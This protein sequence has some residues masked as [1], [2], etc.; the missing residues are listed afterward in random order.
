MKKNSKGFVLF[1]TLVVATFVL[2]ALIFLFVQFSN[3]KKNYEIT[4][5]YNTVPGVYNLKVLGDYI[6]SSA[7]YTTLSNNAKSS[8]DGSKLK[9][10]I[11][12]KS[13]TQAC[14]TTGLN[15]FCNEIIEKINANRVILISGA[16]TTV[17][18]QNLYGLEIFQSYL[19]SLNHD[20]LASAG[21]D[22]EFKEFLLSLDGKENIE[23][24][25]LA[26]EFSDNTFAIILL[27]SS[28]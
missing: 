5:R 22:D 18:G 7:Q 12:I 6:S 11:V 2:G 9:K 24:D 23:K 15:A 13:P 26:V 27:Y 10:Y 8:L 21:F 16:K 28:N 1:E 14:N 19:K 25:R 17:N 3:I 20:Q 4:F